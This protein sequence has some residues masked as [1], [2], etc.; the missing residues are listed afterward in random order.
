MAF[1]FLFDQLRTMLP[2]LTA[3]DLTIAL[4]NHF[5]INH[6]IARS[7]TLA[8]VS[9]VQ[10][11]L[12]HCENLTGIRF[13][14][15]KGKPMGSAV[16]E[17]PAKRQDSIAFFV[18]ET[19][20]IPA[21]ID[22]RLSAIS[23]FTIHLA[24]P[25]PQSDR[26]AAAVTTPTNETNLSTPET[27]PAN[28]QT[29]EQ[30]LESAIADSRDKDDEDFDKEA[31]DSNAATRLATLQAQIAAIM[32]QTPTPRRLFPSTTTPGTFTSMSPKMAQL[33]AAN[34]SAGQLPTYVGS[35]SFLDDQMTFDSIFPSP[36]PLE[37]DSSTS[38]I[39]SESTVPKRID[40]FLHR[41]ELDA[42]ASI[43]RLDYVGSDAATSPEMICQIS[44]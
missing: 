9:A 24:L 39:L 32:A 28:L 22:N 26:T 11:T 44:D 21:T 16:N 7:E 3:T 23:P 27:H 13:L 18:F 41:C 10:A 30:Q 25:L 34:A 6:S 12:F 20:V 4:A 43:L 5:D 42:F 2:T 38:S 40:D 37:E 19:T 31:D 36:L 1:D 35:L 8:I 33:L 17:D 14:N 29:L 15:R